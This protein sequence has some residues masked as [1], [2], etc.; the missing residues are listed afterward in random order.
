MQQLVLMMNGYEAGDLVGKILTVTFLLIMF[1]MV[2]FVMYKYLGSN[3]KK[4]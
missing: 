1:G 3:T 2:V 4:P